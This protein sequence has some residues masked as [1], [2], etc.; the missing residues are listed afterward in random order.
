MTWYVD[1]TGMGYT[2]PE[3]KNVLAG[4]Q[5]VMVTKS[6]WD[7]KQ[8]TDK[9]PITLYKLTS[10]YFQKFCDIY[11]LPYDYVLGDNNTMLSIIEAFVCDVVG[12]KTC[13]VNPNW[14]YDCLKQS[15]LG[16][17]DQLYP[18]FYDRT[19]R[20]SISPQVAQAIEGNPEYLYLLFLIYGVIP[21]NF[22]MDLA[23]LYLG[24]YAP[25]DLKLDD[26]ICFVGTGKAGM[27]QW[28]F[29][30]QYIRRAENCDIFA[31]PAENGL[32]HFDKSGFKLESLLQSKLYKSMPFGGEVNPIAAVDRSLTSVSYNQEMS[33]MATTG[34]KS[35]KS[36]LLVKARKDLTRYR[37]LDDGT[38][39]QS[40]LD[41]YYTD[42]RNFALLEAAL[43]YCYSANSLAA[44]IRCKCAS[45]REVYDRIVSPYKGAPLLKLCS[46]EEATLCIFDTETT[47]LDPANDII[48]EFAAVLL[49]GNQVIDKV[50]ILRKSAVDKMKPEV[51]DLTGITPELLEAEGLDDEEFDETIK[52]FYQANYIMAYNSPFDVSVVDET[53]RVFPDVAIDLLDVVK[54]LYP[55]LDSYKLG[56]VG[57][58]LNLQGS[59]THRA[60]DDVMLTY[61]LY[62][63]CIQKYNSV[64]QGRQEE[65]NNSRKQLVD[66]VNGKVSTVFGMESL[67]KL[68][69]VCQ[70]AIQLQRVDVARSLLM[71]IGVSE[72]FI[73]A[74]WDTSLSVGTNLTRFILKPLS[75]VERGLFAGT[76]YDLKDFKYDTVFLESFDKAH[77]DFI[78]ARANVVI[79][80]GGDAGSDLGLVAQSIKRVEVRCFFNREDMMNEIAYIRSN[81]DAKVSP[82]VYTVTPTYKPGDTNDYNYMRTLWGIRLSLSHNYVKYKNQWD[83]DVVRMQLGNNA[84]VI[85]SFCENLID[86]ASGKGG[87]VEKDHSTWKA[88]TDN[89]ARVNFVDVADSLKEV[90]TGYSYK[91]NAKHAWT[92]A[93]Q[94]LKSAGID[95]RGLEVDENIGMY[96]VLVMGYTEAIEDLFLNKRIPLLLEPL[97]LDVPEAV[98]LIYGMEKE[99]KELYNHKDEHGTIKGSLS[100]IIKEIEAH[101]VFEGLTEINLEMLTDVNMRMIDVAWRS[102]QPDGVIYPFIVDLTRYPHV[103]TTIRNT[104]KMLYEFMISKDCEFYLLDETGVWVEKLGSIKTINTKVLN[105]N[106][107]GKGIKYKR[108]IVFR[109]AEPLIRFLEERK[110][111]KHR[112]FVGVDYRLAGLSKS[113]KR[114]KFTPKRF[115]KQISKHELGKVVLLNRYYTRRNLD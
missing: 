32:F 25:A 37:R 13:R 54:C 24:K 10:K 1:K 68:V 112:G 52:R 81:G 92:S 40:K 73:D 48:V 2:N 12:D 82:A 8:V 41:T 79:Q 30:H 34:D 28:M 39:V 26:N 19:M 51:I 78:K 65:L 107:G 110:L 47:G 21:Y 106:T 22:Y 75:L 6:D 97:G 100:Y 111:S 36:M 93:V 31:R 14:V 89:L 59:N 49:K 64:I 53:I 16:I 69:K 7:W 56:D 46:A 96:S 4:K 29:M 11:K 88:L 84:K 45:S 42:N 23:S 9:E 105:P 3:Y 101:D 76:I 72:H 18:G 63:N 15:T 71:N 43:M 102:Y 35:Q 87:N 85:K 70:K 27:S 66:S 50:D 60:I 44:D 90:L 115:N 55:N 20:Y 58:S 113:S 17:A 114:V 83:K 80:D 95:L 99:I 67:N 57:A 86:I 104:R 98:Q 61:D 108:Y 94:G 38:R 77:L 74:N 5:I 103:G 62:L 91:L 33:T 109:R